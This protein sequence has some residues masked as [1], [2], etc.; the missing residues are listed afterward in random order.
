MF[1]VLCK[2]FTDKKYKDF[3]DYAKNSYQN[4]NDIE[5]KSVIYNV[6]VIIE[7]TLNV[8]SRNKVLPTTT[9]TLTSYCLII[10]IQILGGMQTKI[11]MNP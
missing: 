6:P 4:I 1:C 11:I 3:Y 5:R 2:I 10:I 9:A 8:F 7:K